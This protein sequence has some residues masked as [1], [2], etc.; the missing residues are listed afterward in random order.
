[1]G[2]LSSTLR[3][4]GVKE[5]P[6]DLEILA[7]AGPNRSEMAEVYTLVNATLRKLAE[8]GEKLEPFVHITGEMRALADPIHRALFS[9]PGVLAA[10]PQFVG[11]MP[12]DRTSPTLVEFLTMNKSNWPDLS[13]REHLEVV[14]VIASES[15]ELWL[16]G[17]L[18]P[19]HFSVFGDLCLLQAEHEH[20]TFEKNVWFVRSRE[21][22]RN[23]SPTL[24]RT[25]TSARRL[26]PRTFRRVLDETQTSR[27]LFP[28][29]EG[30]ALERDLAVR[31]WGETLVE[32]QAALEIVKSHGGFLTVSSDG[33]ELL[34]PLRSCMRG[35]PREARLFSLGDLL[36]P[37]APME[38]SAPDRADERPL[39]VA[40]LPS[41]ALTSELL[42]SG[43]RSRPSSSTARGLRG[44]PPEEPA[45]I[46][47]EVVREV[48]VRARA[49]LRSM[50]AT[51][52]YGLFPS[53]RTVWPVAYDGRFD[54]A[55]A[56][57]LMNTLPLS[58]YG[59]D[60]PLAK[61]LDELHT[62]LDSKAPA[63]YWGT[64]RRFGQ[65][66]WIEVH[67]DEDRSASLD[68][69]IEQL[70]TDDAPS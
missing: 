25:R 18:A 38:S 44:G 6:K 7:Q 40:L 57:A 52:T 4:L 13:A 50:F 47:D 12:G 49:A 58:P 21:L 24:D 51:Y 2:S 34:E 23:L 16:S 27:L 3:A 67:S 14:D 5:R 20:P 36:R 29:A 28:L 22:A 59:S 46:S 8:A 17:E 19:M 1:M 55:F 64:V 53:L 60:G 45:A 15:V 9:E 10:R 63:G 62:L 35:N 56:R 48:A 31:S 42:Q 65:D 66:I 33:A 43:G 26:D 69:R 61:L 68:P 11:W 30:A 32:D 37:P 39:G 70:L 41:D 54:D